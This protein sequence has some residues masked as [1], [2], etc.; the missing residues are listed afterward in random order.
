[1]NVMEIAALH[2]GAAGVLA[3]YGLHCVGCSYSEFDS[4][5]EGA[6]THGL[7]DD[8]I[9]MIVEDL[10]ELLRTSPARPATIA[11]T[12]A[13][14][15]ALAAI[16]KSQSKTGYVLRVKTDEQGAFCMDFERQ[17]NPEDSSFTNPAAPTLTFVASPNTL[18]RIGGATIDYRDDRFKLDLPPT[19]GCGCGSG[20]GEC[21]CGKK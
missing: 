7:T 1:M 14:A 9:A 3:E 17:S 18:L 8:D 16:A 4:L 11:V 15:V 6:Y 5:R 12:D 2:P 20:K 19:A 10:H 21:D 13:A